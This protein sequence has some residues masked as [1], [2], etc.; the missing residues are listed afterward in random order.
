MK[1][2]LFGRLVVLKICVHV[3]HDLAVLNLKLVMKV[4][5]MSLP[6]MMLVMKVVIQV[7]KVVMKVVLSFPPGEGLSQMK[8]VLSFG[9]ARARFLFEEMKTVF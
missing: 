8:V 2:V 1:V 7:V 5:I 6:K 3:V 4:V 9:L